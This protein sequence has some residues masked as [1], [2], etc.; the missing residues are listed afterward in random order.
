[1]QRINHNGS[2]CGLVPVIVNIAKTMKMGVIAE[3]VETPEQL[4]LLR[5]LECEFAQG[6]WFSPPVSENVLVDLIKSQ[7]IW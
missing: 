6:Y 3:G 4:S 7:K 5:G 2:S 1:M